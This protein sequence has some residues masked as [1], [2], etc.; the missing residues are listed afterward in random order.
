MS[1]F[2]SQW[3]GLSQQEPRTA[4]RPVPALPRLAG[5]GSR[6]GAAR[7]HGSPAEGGARPEVEDAAG[8]GGGAGEVLSAQDPATAALPWRGEEGG[9][10][11]AGEARRGGGAPAREGGLPERRRGRGRA[12][13]RRGRRP[14]GRCHAAATVPRS[15][16]PSRPWRGIP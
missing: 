10:R 15:R 2:Q 7:P 6:R 3:A 4:R 14:G 9:G 1:C 12:P 8:C 11:G 5:R 16:C 13:G